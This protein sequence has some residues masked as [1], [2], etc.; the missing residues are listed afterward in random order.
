MHLDSSEKQRFHFNSNPST[1]RK[2]TRHFTGL[3]KPMSLHLLGI[4]VSRQYSK[5]SD[6]DIYQAGTLLSEIIVTLFTQKHIPHCYVRQLY[7]F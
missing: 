5:S 7:N 1:V 2:N 4:I 3:Q 6:V